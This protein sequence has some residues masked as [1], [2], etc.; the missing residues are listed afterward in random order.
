MVTPFWTPRDEAI[1]QAGMTK[2]R[3]FANGRYGLDMKTYWDL[4]RWSIGN[5]D[6][7]NDFWSAL[8]EWSGIIGDKGASPVSREGD[9]LSPSQR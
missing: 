1:R 4:H 3:E 7:M 6:E 2:F 8:W 9:Q 5:P